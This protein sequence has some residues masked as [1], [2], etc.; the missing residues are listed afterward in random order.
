M[1]GNVSQLQSCEYHLLQK[2]N[3]TVFILVELD[4]F[5]HLVV[6]LGLGGGALTQCLA[7]LTLDQMV[8]I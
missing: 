3:H 2:Q 5:D 1:G 4:C 8:W 6:I 7:C